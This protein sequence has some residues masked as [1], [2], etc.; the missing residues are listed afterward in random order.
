MAQRVGPRK[1]GT[2]R[3]GIV[4]WIAVVFGL[5][6]L[7]PNQTA[8]ETLN[9][10]IAQ[11]TP[12]MT[13]VKPEGSGPFPVVLLMHG[14]GGRQPFLDTWANSVRDAGAVAV[15]IDSFKPR[16]INRAMA[17]STVCTG[18][19]M[20]GRERA[21]DL[22]AMMAWARVQPW[23]DRE[24]IIAAGWSHGGWT[25]LDALALRAG[26]EMQRAT[27][28]TDLPQE[29]LEGLA[30]AFLLYPYAG[31]ASLA[32]NRPWR[33]APTTYAIVAGRD[34]MVGA[35]VPRAAL[36]RLRAQGAPIE[37]E[38]YATQTHAFDEREAADLRV[39]YDAEATTRAQARLAQL[40]A[41][42]RGASAGSSP[43]R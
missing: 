13:V 41:H 36:E 32:G 39:R 30:G 21:G 43:A 7:M 15:V 28:L 3:P 6:L 11:L 22:Y 29:P 17:L 35:N 5:V 33:I 24:R 14:C 18:M 2:R 40:I 34:Y 42:V 4:I 23:A 26:D 1:S 27:G 10:R 31:R 25:V 9:Q 38:T 20:W 37:I 12:A 19:R 8:A 16:G